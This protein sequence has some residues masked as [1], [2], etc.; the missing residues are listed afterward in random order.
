MAMDFVT[1][2]PNPKAF[3]M[4]VNFWWMGT[5]WHSTQ[6]ATED[7]TISKTSIDLTHSKK[8]GRSD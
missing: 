7:I 8:V 3:D 1:E 2:V 5:V 6:A 4:Q